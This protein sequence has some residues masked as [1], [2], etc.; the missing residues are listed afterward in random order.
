MPLGFEREMALSIAWHSF[1]PEGHSTIAQRFSVGI[2]GE[3][4]QSRRDD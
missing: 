1:V 3:A 4:G 2:D